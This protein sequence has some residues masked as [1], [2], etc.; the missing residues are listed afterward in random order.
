MNIYHLWFNLHLTSKDLEFSDAL[1]EY[2]DYLKENGLIE[3]WR[4]TRQKLGFGPQGLGE[5][6]ATME[7][8]SMEQLER[9]FEHVATRTGRVEELH[10]K[11]YAAV[12]DLKTSMHRDFP[13][14]ERVR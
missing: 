5:F 11:V 9:A 3:G 4:L 12:K 6:H 1:R 14:P 10:K 8:K 13:D 2:M 7:V